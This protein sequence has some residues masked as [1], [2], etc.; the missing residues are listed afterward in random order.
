MEEHPYLRA[1]F[2]TGEIEHL[3]PTQDVCDGGAQSL[4]RPS[5]S[6]PLRRCA[7]AIGANG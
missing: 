6:P 7:A 2:E 3:V 5:L 4:S 1:E